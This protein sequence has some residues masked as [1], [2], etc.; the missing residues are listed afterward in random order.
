MENSD[1]LFEIFV[2]VFMCA[3]LLDKVKDIFC[4][5]V[6]TDSIKLERKYYMQN[7]K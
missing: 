4:I 5:N 7:V 6:K 3:H 1:E 2:L